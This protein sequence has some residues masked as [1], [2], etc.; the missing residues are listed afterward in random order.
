ML[1]TGNF[2]SLWGN[3]LAAAQDA[4]PCMSR[5]IPTLAFTNV[6]FSG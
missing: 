5:L 1:I 4:R 2:L 3:L 6:D